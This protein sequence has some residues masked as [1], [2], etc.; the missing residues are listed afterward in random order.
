MLYHPEFGLFPALSYHPPWGAGAGA[1]APLA[2]VCVPSVVLPVV[3]VRPPSTPPFAL[4]VE[5]VPLGIFSL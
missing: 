4:A 1:G 2:P 5:A 3:C